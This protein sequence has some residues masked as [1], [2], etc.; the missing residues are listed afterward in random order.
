MARRSVRVWPVL[1][2]MAA[3]LVTGA[4]T[5]AAHAAAASTLGVVGGILAALVAAMIVG[6][7]FYIV[8]VIVWSRDSNVSSRPSP[9]PRRSASPRSSTRR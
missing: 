5:W 4:A 9:K 1:F 6:A 2:V 8:S 3:C 7:P